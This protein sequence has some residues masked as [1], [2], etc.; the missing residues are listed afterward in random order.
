MNLIGFFVQWNWYYSK[1]ISENWSRIYLTFRICRM[2]CWVLRSIIIILEMITY[3]Y[4]SKLYKK[5]VKLR[6]WCITLK[7]W[8]LSKSQKG[9]Q[10]RNSHIFVGLS[11]HCRYP[12][13]Y[14]TRI[15]GQF[16]PYILLCGIYSFYFVG[17]SQCQ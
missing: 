7:S 10:K 3:K 14:L 4:K 17:V 5:I 2:V 16:W 13:Y 12:S 11:L 15:W 8:G 9:F 6:P 1:N